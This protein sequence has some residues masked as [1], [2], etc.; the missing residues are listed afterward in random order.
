MNKYKLLVVDD[1]PTRASQICQLLKDREF[2]VTVI[3]KGDK[4]LDRIKKNGFD[5]ILTNILLTDMDSVELVVDIQKYQPDLPVII[6]SAPSQGSKTIKALY[7]GAHHFVREPFKLEEVIQTIEKLL[8]YR[9]QEIVK[10]KVIPYI[11]DDV[12]FNIPSD[13]SIMGAVVQYITDVLVKIGLQKEDDIHIKIALLEAVTNA[14]EHGNKKSPD[15]L[16]MIQ[17]TMTAEKAVFTV[18]DEG[19]GFDYKNLPDPTKPD[20][21]VKVR[22]R[23]VFMIYRIMDEIVFNKKGNEIRMV[24][25][26]PRDKT[27]GQ[28]K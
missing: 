10:K 6:M 20:N 14:I 3:R 23:G 17:A 24:K 18:R 22:G 25:Y 11:Q 9:Q 13:F 21:I 26:A 15:K 28:K 4:A 7:A 1:D 16:V 27:P 12:K 8:R 5:L 2:D 19:S